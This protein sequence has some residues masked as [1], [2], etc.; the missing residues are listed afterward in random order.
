MRLAGRYTV[1]HGAFTI[2]LLLLALVDGVDFLRGVLTI[3]WV[4]PEPLLRLSNAVIIHLRSKGAGVG[5][6]GDR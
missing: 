6:V 2:L 3:C 4:Q 5:I 1:W